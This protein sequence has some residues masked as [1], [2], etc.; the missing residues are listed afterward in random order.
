MNFEQHQW[1][2]ITHHKKNINETDKQNT[3]IQNFLMR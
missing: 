3:A 1:K 2:R